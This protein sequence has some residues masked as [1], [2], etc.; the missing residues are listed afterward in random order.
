MAVASATAWCAAAR[1]SALRSRPSPTTMSIESDANRA[2]ATESSRKPRTEDISPAL[3]EPA[4]SIPGYRARTWSIAAWWS[5]PQALIRSPAFG[6][7][8]AR[9]AS[10]CAKTSA[11]ALARSTSSL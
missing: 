4:S 3:L 1:Q 10:H 9:P 5:I 7:A 6:A 8:P 2:R 11:I